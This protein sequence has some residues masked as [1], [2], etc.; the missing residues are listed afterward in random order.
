MKN[1]H[2]KVFLYIFAIGFVLYPIYMLVLAH[3]NG[4]SPYSGIIDRIFL[5]SYA[6]PF[7][8]IPALI[9]F[10]L[11]KY[12]SRPDKNTPDIVS[13][14]K[15]SSTGQNLSRTLI[16]IVIGLVLVFSCWWM[17]SLT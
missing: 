17:L 8:W 3:Q 5:T 9:L 10:G 4:S 12:F 16:L 2:I 14:Y 1:K 11:G 6:I 13:Q 7:F 15:I